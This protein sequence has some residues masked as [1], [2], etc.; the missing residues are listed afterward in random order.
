MRQHGLSESQIRAREA[1]CVPNAH[2][3]TLK[4][5]KDYSCLQGGASREYRNR[6]GRFRPRDRSDRLAHRRI[7]ATI[8]RET[9][10]LQPS[11]SRTAPAPASRAEPEGQ[12]DPRGDPV[13]ARGSREDRAPPHRCSR[14]MARSS[15]SSSPRC[16]RR[17]AGGCSS[18]ASRWI[19]PAP[20]ELDESGVDHIDAVVDRL[21]V[22]LQARESDQG[23]HRGNPARGRRVAP[24]GGHQG[25][26]RRGERAVLPGALQA[27]HAPPRLRRHRTPTTSS[28][29]SRRVPAGPAAA[30][31]S[32]S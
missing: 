29:T 28:S 24:G 32:T 8:R 4:S 15:T 27:P 5:L 30:W 20:L 19:S 16:A 31:G 22:E 9:C 2:E 3:Q 7:G 6:R 17:A 21:T 11:A 25:R 1:E 12:P 10:C 26:E 13:A 14:S 18:T 23:G